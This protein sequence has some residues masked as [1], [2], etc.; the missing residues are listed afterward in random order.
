MAT[1]AVTSPIHSKTQCQVSPGT[2]VP[3][4]AFMGLEEPPSMC[5]VPLSSMAK[6]SS[7]SILVRLQESLHRG[8]STPARF[9][10]KDSQNPLQTPGP[11]PSRLRHSQATLHDSKCCYT[12]LNLQENQ[13]VVAHRTPQP[14]TAQCSKSRT[15]SKSLQPKSVSFGRITISVCIR[16]RKL[17]WL[18]VNEAAFST[19]VNQG[20]YSLHI[21]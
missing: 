5:R 19:S 21:S 4:L 2:H 17:L 14:F 20:H 15:Q 11:T 6:S 18:A 9:I 12:L 3:V 7:P 10:I 13:W 16:S 1:T 8:S